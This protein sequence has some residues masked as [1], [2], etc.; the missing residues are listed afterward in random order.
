MNLSKLIVIDFKTSTKLFENNYQNTI[1]M[2]FQFH[3]LRKFTKTYKYQTLY[4]S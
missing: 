1:D 3:T 2:V 4:L